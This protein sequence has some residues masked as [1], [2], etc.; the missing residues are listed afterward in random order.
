MLWV[1]IVQALAKGV[2]AGA[3]ILTLS[4]G[5][6]GGW[7]NSTV[8]AMVNEIVRSG[9]VVTIAA[10]NEGDFGAWFAASPAS[11]SEAIAIG[12]VDKSVF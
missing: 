6:P 4:L 2:Q 8:S 11:A 1:V 9:K 12:S 3:D 10:G 7:E 5:G